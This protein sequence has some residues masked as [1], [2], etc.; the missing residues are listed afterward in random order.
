VRRNLLALPCILLEGELFAV[1]G[2]GGSSKAMLRS[3]ENFNDHRLRSILVFVG[4]R[5]K[6]SGRHTTAASRFL[7][8]LVTAFMWHHRQQ[9]R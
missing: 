8:F 9:I 1:M 2:L 4:A 6:A 5:G 7:Q 3:T